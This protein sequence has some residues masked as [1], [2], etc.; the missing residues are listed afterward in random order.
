MKKATKKKHEDLAKKGE[1]V[2]FIKKRVPS[3]KKS[4]NEEGGQRE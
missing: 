2:F 3:K 1:I 4:K